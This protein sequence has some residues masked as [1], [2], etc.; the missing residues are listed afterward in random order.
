MGQ[1]Q[2]GD[3]SYKSMFKR[4]KYRVFIAMSAQ[5]FAQLVRNNGLEER[6]LS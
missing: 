2:V 4:Y 1:R 6:G 5:A 3:R